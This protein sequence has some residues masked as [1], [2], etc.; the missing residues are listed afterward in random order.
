[1]CPLTICFTEYSGGWGLREG[2]GVVCPQTICFT[3][4]SGG[5]GV[6]RGLRWDGGSSLCGCGRKRSSEWFSVVVVE[7]G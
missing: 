2:S 6:W 3:E 4:Y 5:C 7:V 1:M